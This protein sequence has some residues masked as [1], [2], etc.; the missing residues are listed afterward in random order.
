MITIL[1][2]LIIITAL[3]IIIRANSKIIRTRKIMVEI[4]VL[5]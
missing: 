4:N 3:V 2:L 1:I 5:Q